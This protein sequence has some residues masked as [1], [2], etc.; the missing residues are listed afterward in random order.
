MTCAHFDGTSGSL[1][2]R[3]EKALAMPCYGMF[4]PKTV[5]VIKARRT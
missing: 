2:D 1:G 3:D 5:E 4:I